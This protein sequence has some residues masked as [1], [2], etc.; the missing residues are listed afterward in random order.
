[1]DAARLIAAGTMRLERANGPEVGLR[2]VLVRVEAAGICGS[3]RHMF[4]GEYPTALPVI[5]GHEFCGHRRGGGRR[6]RAAEGRRPGDG[7][8]EH[9]LRPLSGVPQR[10]GQSLPQPRGDR[11]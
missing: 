3:D 9:R 10:T 1:M 8:P 11:G 4:R 2:D 7:G 6:G 5:L